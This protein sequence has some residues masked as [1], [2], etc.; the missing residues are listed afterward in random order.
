MRK[1]FILLIMLFL[2]N[3]MSAQ[4]LMTGKNIIET[5]DLI[6]GFS[7]ECM[8]ED[9]IELEQTLM[10]IN[11]RLKANDGIY[12]IEKELNVEYLNNNDDKIFLISGNIALP[13]NSSMLEG[14]DKSERYR[15]IGALV[16]V[17]LINLR[18]KLYKE[19]TKDIW[20]N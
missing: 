18:N 6:I 2:Y 20:K 1:L 13:L 7:Y 17:K 9:S 4:M 15:Y 19:N 5:Y 12:E 16:D 14:L 10:Y 11:T 8:L 3:N